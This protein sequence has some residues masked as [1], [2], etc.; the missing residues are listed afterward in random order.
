LKKIFFFPFLA[1]SFFCFLFQGCKKSKPVASTLPDATQQGKNTF[2]FKLDGKVWTP[3]AKCK[4]F[5]NP[6]EEAEYQGL[7]LPNIRSP[8]ISFGATNENGS[9]SSLIS[10][11]SWIKIT[12]PG[13]YI[14]SMT[15]SF[16]DEDRNDFGLP[17]EPSLKGYHFTITKIDSMGNIVSGTF[18][19]TLFS[20]LQ[21]DPRTIKITEGRFDVRFPYCNCSE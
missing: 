7:V 1:F 11:Y 12:K 5:G 18:A 2:G 6:C 13:N 9:K 10:I 4:N 21:G 20:R 16:L 3:Y 19:F 17:Y 8:Q 14:D 15:I